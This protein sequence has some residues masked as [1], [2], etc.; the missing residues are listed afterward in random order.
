MP[1]TG[2]AEQ[3]GGPAGQQH[4]DLVVRPHRGDR[5][6]ERLGGGQRSGA[7]LRMVAGDDLKSGVRGGVEGRGY[8][9]SPGR[10]HAPPAED[11]D[12]GA[13]HRGRGL[14]EGEHERRAQR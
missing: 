2:A 12:R 9:D 3:T 10:L 7:G 4:P 11:F 8:N 5:A 6:S 13:R 14:A 1:S